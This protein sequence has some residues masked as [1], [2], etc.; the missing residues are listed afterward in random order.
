MV[1]GI[2]FLI[3]AV[4]FFWNRDRAPAVLPKPDFGRSVFMFIVGGFFLALGIASYFTFVFTSGLTFDF[5]R[6]VWDSM[7]AK[8]YVA[9]IVVPL[10]VA[11]G[12]G[13]CLSALLAPTLI[14]A[15]MDTSMI[16]FLP[17]LGMIGLLQIVQFMVLIWAPLERRIITARLAAKGIG[18]DLLRTA[19]LI[20]ISDPASGITK[21][22]GTIEED[23]GALWVTPD[24]ISYRGDHEQFDITRDRLLELERKADKR[25]TTM[26]AGIAHIILHVKLTDG[27]LRQ[28][29]LHTEGLW[30]MAEKRKAMDALSEAIAHWHAHCPAP[31]L[32]P[33]A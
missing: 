27:G 30:T 17:V 20:G 28:I 9:N 31:P 4:A 14:R 6:P 11:M 3:L 33:G 29:R 16:D 22:F 19:V 25:S 10:L 5:S 15:G 7:K 26:L 24:W 21:R 18:A 8:I 23:M 2:L 32:P 13:F 12:I 1:I